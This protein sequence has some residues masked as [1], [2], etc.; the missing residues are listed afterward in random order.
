[1]TADNRNSMHQDLSS[2]RRTEIDYITGYLLARAAVHDVDC[3]VN[4]SLYEDI[5]RREAGASV[6]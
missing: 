6:R 2:G 5:K 3:P 1:V 4:E